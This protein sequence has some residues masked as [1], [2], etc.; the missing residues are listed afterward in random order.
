MNTTFILGNGF[1]VCLGLKTRYIEFYKRHYLLLD[2]EDLSPHL[3]AFRKSIH[4]Y[5]S[6]DGK[7]SDDTIDWSD[8]ELALGQYSSY[9][10]NPQEYLDVILDINRELKTYISAQDDAFTT[11][12]SQA[13]K[14]VK[15]FSQPESTKYMSYQDNLDLKTFKRNLQSAEM[16]SFM[17]FN[18]TSTLEKILEQRDAKIALSNQGGYTVTIKDVL[19]IH[20]S[21]R[22]DPA[23][24]VG[25]NSP[26][27][28]A[29]SAFRNNPDILD[30][31]VKPRTNDMFG[32]GKNASAI[33]LLNN[34]QLIVLFGVSIGD[35]DRK[36]WEII[37][38]RLSI[39]A[40]RVIYFVY[41]NP[42]ETNPLLLGRKR[43]EYQNKLLKA[44]SIP[45]KDH[46]NLRGW[47]TIA[48]NTNYLM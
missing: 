47:I 3:K 19:H 21:I 23:I 4:Q 32:N 13:N 25:V 11:N 42:E 27:Q 33:N 31:V 12:T 41:D 22:R 45:E 43:R 24:L 18:Y 8:L 16:I 2:R 29:N 9:L 7:K 48:Y 40:C 5:V 15:D 44:A 10:E 6:N 20:S 36:W 26:D 30:V 14:I 34:S 46:N 38:S 39:S 1:D 37:G 35:T 28:I 17:T